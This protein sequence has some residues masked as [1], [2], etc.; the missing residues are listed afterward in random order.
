[1]KVESKKPV[2]ANETPQVVGDKASV[3]Q[4]A[5]KL[6][7]LQEKTNTGFAKVTIDLLAIK[8]EFK[9]EIAKI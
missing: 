7:T 1:M 5:E 6:E 8:E 9:A 4:T 3:D 2:E